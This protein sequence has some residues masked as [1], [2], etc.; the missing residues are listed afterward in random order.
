MN[1][2]C[3]ADGRQPEIKNLNRAVHRPHQVAWFDIAVH[4]AGTVRVQQSKGSLANDR[5][6]LTD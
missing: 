3:I 1:Q 2:T 5:G 4:D 6:S